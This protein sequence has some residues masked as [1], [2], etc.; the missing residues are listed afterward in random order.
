MLKIALTTV[1]V[2]VGLLFLTLLVAWLA[3][4]GPD[5]PA[6]ELRSRF[7][8]P[9]DHYL[10]LGEI[11][12]HYR[13][14]G[15]QTAP[16]LVLVHG[17]GDSF[18]AWEKWV[19]LLKDR[20][21]LIQVD[22]PGHGLT[23]APAT[24][25]LNAEGY[26]DLLDELAATL[27]LPPFAVVGNSMG[28]AV[29]WQLALRH[30]Q[31]LNA[32]I[33]LDAAGWPSPS[34]AQSPSLAFRILQHPIGRWA[35][36]H[37]DNRPLIEQGLRAQVHDQNVITTAQ[38]DRWAAFQRLP[39]HRPI[40][41]SARPGAHLLATPEALARIGVPTLVIHGQ[42]DTLIPVASSQGF[43]GAIPGA[44]LIVYPDSGHLPQWEVPEKSARD[45]DAFLTEA[46]A[47]KPGV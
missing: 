33:L 38:I 29:A 2:L 11:T 44:R 12:L 24:T 3:L 25:A 35:L 15:P 26:A 18:T 20:Y 46:R 14:E 4:R 30:P 28:G 40:L 17:Y 45:V 7:G 27:Q 10:P 5:I 32:L 23:E 22:M 21:R 37:I 39:G 36:E 31:R 1:A 41:M 34:L 13:D 42:S 8:G 43:A 6:G 16:A 47:R 19:P 9:D